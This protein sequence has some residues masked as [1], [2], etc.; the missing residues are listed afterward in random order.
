MHSMQHDAWIGGWLMADDHDA[1]KY[2]LCVTAHMQHDAWIIGWLMMIMKQK[3]TLF[4]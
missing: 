2:A 3:S 1:K 4:A